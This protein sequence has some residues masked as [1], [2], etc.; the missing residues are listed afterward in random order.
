MGKTKRNL[1]MMLLFGIIL[2]TNTA[3]PVVITPAAG[4]SW[5]DVDWAYTYLYKGMMLNWYAYDS[6]PWPSQARW[7]LPGNVEFTGFRPNTQFGS[8]FID[9]NFDRRLDVPNVDYRFAVR[10]L[11]TTRSYVDF[12]NNE[13][14]DSGD[15]TIDYNSSGNRFDFS[16]PGSGFMARGAYGLNLQPGFYQIKTGIDNALGDVPLDVTTQS[17]TTHFN[18]EFLNNTQILPRVAYG[19]LGNG[20]NLTSQIISN[21]SLGIP[22]VGAL[23]FFN[24]NG[25]DLPFELGG[26]TGN[27]QTWTVPPFTSRIWEPA[28]P[29]A[30][31]TSGWATA[32][33]GVQY[34][35]NYGI[36]STGA[37]KNSGGDTNP[38]SVGTL[39]IQAGIGA[40]GV[41]TR[42]VMNVFKAP[43]GID[44]A[45]AIVNPTSA[46]AAITLI[47]SD[48]TAEKARKTLTLGPRNGT[49]RF[50]GEFF[51]LDVPSFS[52]T[53]VIKS[54]TSVATTSLRTLN[55]FPSTS[56]PSGSATIR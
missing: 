53:L 31:V 39:S 36:Y 11:T 26:S 47:L 56:L 8:F 40:S 2:I 41:S 37:R 42:H 52:G 21:N 54:D 24:D 32:Y 29:V 19:D 1:I 20:L 5:A 30:P 44:T 38:A 3:C 4:G 7:G 10:G 27:L 50:F 48:A 17:G 15:A 13:I 22:M 28:N 35:V 9:G 18:L 23:R 33:G 14:L 51:G 49:S 34:S 46:T 6:V 12:N 16:F 25:S 43:G 45:F 55:G